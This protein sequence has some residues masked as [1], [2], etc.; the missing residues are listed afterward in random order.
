MLHIEGAEYHSHILFEFIIVQSGKHLVK[1]ED[2][3]PDVIYDCT[4]LNTFCA[5][6]DNALYR[7]IDQD[8]PTVSESD[9][10]SS[11]SDV[12]VVDTEPLHDAEE[13][14]SSNSVNYSRQ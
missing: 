3:T 11:P 2:N 12:P 14:T 9:D 1:F 6:L 13:N 4:G 5:A 8:D 7:R 10:E